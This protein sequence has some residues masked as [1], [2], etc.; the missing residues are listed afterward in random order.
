MA[1]G[2]TFVAMLVLMFVFIMATHKR[3]TPFFINYVL[4]INISSSVVN[5]IAATTMGLDNLLVKPGS[6]GGS[7][8]A[9]GASPGCRPTK[10]PRRP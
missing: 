1:M 2:A 9:G 6:T 10:A 3:F 8:A 4:I 5:G 7:P